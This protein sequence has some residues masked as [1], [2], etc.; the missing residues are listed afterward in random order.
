MSRPATK[1]SENRM[2]LEK[3]L[4]AAMRVASRAEPTGGVERQ[5]RGQA[6][7]VGGCRGHSGEMPGQRAAVAAIEQA[8]HDR[9]AEGRTDLSGRCRSP[10]RRHLVGR[11]E[12]TRRWRWWPP[13]WPDRSPR[14]GSPE[15]RVAGRTRCGR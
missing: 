13:S 11:S 7:L 14:P 10:P 9:D 6:G 2:P 12:V 3:A 5:P 1:S 15:L 4:R 8:A